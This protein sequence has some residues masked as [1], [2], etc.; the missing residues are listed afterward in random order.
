MLLDILNENRIVTNCDVA[1][2]KEAIEA[3]G[4]L[5][6]DDGLIEPRYIDAMVTSVVENGPY[7][8]VSEGIAIAH[9]RPENGVNQLGMSLVI[10]K[11]AI[12]FGHKTNDPVKL[13]FSFGAVNND[14]HIEAFRELT[15][16]LMNE[17]F[18]DAV[19]S[20]K[21]STE[22]YRFIK[23]KLSEIEQ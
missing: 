13:V 6:L 2:W 7:I 5:L 16:L 11:D 10:L 15:K 19:D 22:V 9:A 23:Q 1:D 21:S 3:S 14:D 17:D 12:K 20:M 18:V 4:K 8:V